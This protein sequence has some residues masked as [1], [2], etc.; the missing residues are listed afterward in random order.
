MAIDKPT[1]ARARPTSKADPLGWARANLFNGWFNSALS[2]AILLLLVWLVPPAFQWAVLLF[3]FIKE[4]VNPL[5][6]KL[7]HRPP[8]F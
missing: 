4:E 7:W 8:I 1:A 2:V 5:S 3:W 6:K